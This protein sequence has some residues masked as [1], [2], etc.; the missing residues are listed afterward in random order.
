MEMMHCLFLYS[1]CLTMDRW[2]VFMVRGNEKE[3]YKIHREE[4][5]RTIFYLDVVYAQVLQKASVP[6]V[7]LYHGCQETLH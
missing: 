5:M 6:L 1:I 7:D 2:M 3:I 4:K